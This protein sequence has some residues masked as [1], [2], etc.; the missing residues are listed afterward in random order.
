VR[1]FEVRWIG[2]LHAASSLVSCTSSSDMSYASIMR[3]P[4]ERCHHLGFGAPFSVVFE[5]SALIWSILFRV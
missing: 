3:R 2:V 5:N 1:V 4:V